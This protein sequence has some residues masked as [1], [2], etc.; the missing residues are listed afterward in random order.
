MRLASSA[1]FRL[2]RSLLR[3]FVIIL[4]PECV[5]TDAAAKPMDSARSINARHSSAVRTPETVKT[6]GSTNTGSNVIDLGRPT[7]GFYDTAS[8]RSQQA[9]QLRLVYQKETT[10]PK[11]RCPRRD[12]PKDVNKVSRRCKPNEAPTAKP[13]PCVKTMLGGS[14]P[15]LRPGLGVGSRFVGIEF[16]VRNVK[17]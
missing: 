13:R 4:G 1:S 7:E 17:C 16:D 10:L 11:R 12:K 14:E 6:S 9:S 8:L 5:R 15:R 2:T 3:I